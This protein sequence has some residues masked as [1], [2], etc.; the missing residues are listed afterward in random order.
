MAY[1]RGPAR[2]WEDTPA[3]GDRRPAVRSELVEG[4]RVLDDRGACLS[5]LSCVLGLRYLGGCQD[6]VGLE[7]LSVMVCVHAGILLE[8]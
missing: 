5:W 4:G 2:G 6:L 8:V 1:S 3:R 7:G